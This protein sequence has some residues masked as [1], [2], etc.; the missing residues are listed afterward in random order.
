M[1][2]LSAAMLR[3]GAARLIGARLLEA[4]SRSEFTFQLV[5]FAAI[6]LFSAVINDTTTVLIWMPLILQTCR[7]RGYAPSRLLLPLAYASLLGGQWTLIGTRSNIILSDYLRARTGDGLP[8]FAFT[9]IAAAIWAL[10]IAYFVV[11]GR[12]LLPRTAADASAPRRYDVEEYLTEVLVEGGNAVAGK[13]LAQA[14]LAETHDV[15]VLGVIRGSERHAASPLLLLREGD[16]LIVQ[17][18][19]ARITKLLSRPEFAVREELKLGDKTLRSVDLRMVEC[20]VAPGSLLDGRSLE[21]VAFQLRF[22]ELG[23]IAL[24]RRGHAVAGRPWQQE[25][26][27]GDGLLVV[28]HEADVERLRRDRDF[29]VLESDPLPVTQLRPALL[30]LGAVAFVVLASVTRLLAPAVAIPIAAAFVVLARLIGV[31]D[32]YRSLDLH[33]LVVVAA[34]IPFGFALEKTGTAKLAGQAISST[35]NDLGSHALLAALLLT[36]VLLTQLIENAAVAVILAPI[37]FAAAKETGADPAGFLLGIAICTSSAFMSPVAHESTV[38][39]MNPGGYR[40][41]DYLRFGTALAVL[42]WI[43]TTLLIP[44]FYRV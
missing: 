11:I 42:T 5:I 29:F 25:L 40:F 32:A 15:T 19:I 27:A 7:E 16:V 30:A 36:T 23:V 6:T 26:R 43:A 21:D 13:T 20:L 9:P 22:P 37:G 35:F 17:G 18:R 2:V 39:V 10:A 44:V 31:R 14:R 1:F 33:A 28:G 4:G 38:L 8:F 34:M 12:R 41:R 24:R 3:T